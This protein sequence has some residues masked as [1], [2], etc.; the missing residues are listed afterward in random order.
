MISCFTF[1]QQIGPA[2]VPVTEEREK[3]KCAVLK[4]KLVIFTFCI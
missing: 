2:K 1:V 4:V 3:N